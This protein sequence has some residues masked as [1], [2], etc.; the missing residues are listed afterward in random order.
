MKQSVLTIDILISVNHNK[1]YYY[2]QN[3]LHVPAVQ[4]IVRH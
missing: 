3:L 2:R 4:G 1:F